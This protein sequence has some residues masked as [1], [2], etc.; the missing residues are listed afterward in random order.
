[1][2]VEPV[3]DLAVVHLKER[4]VPPGVEFTPIYVGDERKGTEPCPVTIVNGSMTGEPELVR[5]LFGACQSFES[6]GGAWRRPSF[7]PG[8]ASLPQPKN[9]G[10]T[11][12]ASIVTCSLRAGVL[13]ALH[14]LR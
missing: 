5:S 13:S 4:S 7:R 6:G 11:V 1:M 2:L 10:F 9:K 12:L 14:K 3:V 8:R